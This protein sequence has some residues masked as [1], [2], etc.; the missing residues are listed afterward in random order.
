MAS[1]RTPISYVRR[2]FS[3]QTAILINAS[4]SLLCSS[5]L[6]ETVALF[7]QGRFQAGAVIASA[8]G[9]E[10]ESD[11]YRNA[12]WDHVVTAVNPIVPQYARFV[13]PLLLFASP[14]KPFLFTDKGTL[15]T[16]ATLAQYQDE[17]GE[18]YQAFQSGDAD[19]LTLPAS[20]FCVGDRGAVVHYLTDLASSVL[21]RPL[22]VDEDVFLGGGDS[23]LA[24][25]VA[26]A[27][28]AALRRSGAKKS[29]PQN[30]VYN[31]PTISGLADAVLQALSSE[32]MDDVQHPGQSE[33]AEVVLA[34][35]SR[36][37]KL[38]F[39]HFETLNSE[40]GARATND[41][42]TRLNDVLSFAVTGTTGSLGVFFISMLLKTPAVRKIYLL[43][44]KH[45]DLSDY[46]IHERAFAAKGADFKLLLDALES[47]RAIFV[48]IDLS[49]PRLGIDLS[50]YTHVCFHLQHHAC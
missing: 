22:Q 25:R 31:Y 29:L 12:V 40:S 27:L 37:T 34:T 41:N 48:E 21:G 18:A 43:H 24:M 9:Q 20:G 19:A 26:A 35:L 5:Q 23:L 47:G 10:S 30:V 32:P 38:L 15:Q 16:K 8:S 6:V 42:T 11:A 44:R 45:L 17:I 39:A 36:H 28:G 50:M 4:D 1:R 14:D 33:H 46:Q 49:K 13:R 3:Q 2:Y 7:G